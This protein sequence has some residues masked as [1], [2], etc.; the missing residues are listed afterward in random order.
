MEEKMASKLLHVVLWE[1]EDRD[2]LLEALRKAG[3]PKGINH[4]YFRIEED[5]LRMIL[6][7][8]REGASTGK[9]EINN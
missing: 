5:K 3:L 2:R 8:L 4:L 9:K 1:A 6:Q 7:A